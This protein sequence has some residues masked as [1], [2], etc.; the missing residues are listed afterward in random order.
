MD[1]RPRR[2]ERHRQPLHT[3]PSLTS[4]LSIAPQTQLVR[5][6]YSNAQKPRAE[7]GQALPR[8]LPGPVSHPLS[9]VLS[10]TTPPPPTPGTGSP[11]LLALANLSRKPI[12]CINRPRLLSSVKKDAGNT[13]RLGEE[14][15]AAPQAL[16][17]PTGTAEGHRPRAVPSHTW[18][19]CEPLS[20]T[21]VVLPS[22]RLS[23]LL[24]GFHGQCGTNKVRGVWSGA[25][26][27]A[28]GLLITDSML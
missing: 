12:P 2:S 24:S 14:Q 3:S 19:G 15:R 20:E 16:G 26:G 21:R 7:H 25:G 11:P 13:C 5:V 18:G 6:S 22:Q 17:R 4:R 9:F 28:L 23:C 1:A 10:Q 8:P 27:H